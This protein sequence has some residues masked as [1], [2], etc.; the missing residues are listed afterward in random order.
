MYKIFPL[1]A[2]NKNLKAVINI[3]HVC[4]VKINCYSFPFLMKSMRMSETLAAIGNSC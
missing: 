1:D 3:L 4:E 2:M